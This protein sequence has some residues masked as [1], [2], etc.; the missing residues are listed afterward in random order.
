MDARRLYAG[1]NI[2]DRQ[3][4]DRE[5]RYCGKV[6]DVELAR[7]EAT[8]HLFVTAV[9]SGPGALAYRTGHHRLGRW[10]QRVNAFVFPRDDEDHDPVR[11]PIGRIAEI[12]HHLSFAGDHAETGGFSAE[13]WTRDHVIGPIPGSRDAPQ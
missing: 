12:G 5:G 13:R 11:I 4:L 8:G 3:I 1:L 10:L 2:L 6:D 9:L 7:D